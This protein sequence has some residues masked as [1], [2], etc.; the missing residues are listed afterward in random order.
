MSTAKPT[1]EGTQN[2]P[3]LP[4][5]RA[6]A[7]THP[8]FLASL[9][10][11]LADANRPGLA[12]L[13]ARSRDDFTP[14]LLDA[15]AAV[16]DTLGLYAE[17]QANENYLRT[18]TLRGSLR[19]HARL[20]GYELAPAKAA[21]VHL[22]FEA[23]PVDPAQA[24]LD[25][26]PGLRV[27]S[28]PRDG[29]LPL[30]FETV[31]P[32]TARAD[33]NAMRPLMTW[34]QQLA[35]EAEEITLTADGPRVNIGDA[36]L[37]MQGD[38][39]VAT[40]PDTSGRFLR[41]VSGLSAGIGGR[42][43][44]ALRADPVPA[45]PYTQPVTHDAI[46]SPGI[47]LSTGS[48]VATLAGHSWSVATL[49]Q[50]PD[51]G[52]LGT[53]GLRKAIEAA[54]FAAPAT[55]SPCVMR[56]RAGFFGNIA[57]PG[58]LPNHTAADEPGSIISTAVLTGD[59]PGQGGGKK[60]VANPA[61]LV[62]LDREY[63]EI[64][65]G[66]RLLIRDIANEAW[67]RV[68]AAEPQSIAAYGI[69]A[70]V[71]RLT[72]KLIASSDNLPQE[73]MRFL[74]KFLIRRATCHALPEPLPLAD[75]PITD[76]VGEAQKGGI[77]ADQVELATPELELVPGKTVA[78]TGTRADLDGVTATDIRTIAANIIL[79]DH[80]RLT[81][82]QPLTHRF[83][84]DSVRICANV[85][86][87]THGETVAE[88]MGDGDAT[89]TFQRFRLKSGPLTHV[90]ARN[91]RGMAP[92]LEIRVNRVRWDLVE[93][94]RASGPGDRVFI[95]RLDEDGAA[96]VIFGDGIRGARLPTGQDNVEAIYRR[97]AGLAGHLEAGQLSLLAG[98]PQGLR[99]VTNPLPPAG[100]ADAEALEDAR[101]NAPM[102]VMTLGR[103][104]SL[105]DYEDFARSFAAVA[106]ARADW[107]F[108][109]F[110][111]PILITVAGQGGAMLPETG[112]DMRNLRAALAAAGEADLRVSVRNHAPVGFGV[113]ARLFAD[114]AW[115]PE[116]VIAAAR[117]AVMAA[118]SFDR[119]ALG[120]AVSQAQVVAAL[121]AVPGVRGVDLDALY[122]G[123]TPALQTRLG[124]AVGRPD[125]HGALPVAAELLTLDPARLHLEVAT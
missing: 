26:P 72:V 27:R 68:V 56:L 101:R 113:A 24:V 31:E 16:L 41:R 43:I 21:S 47:P 20:I 99:G 89:R 96:H 117:Q 104:V 80:S 30:I 19:A 59:A 102:G 84:R 114:P 32:L 4:R 95:L 42:R 15:W 37:L 76:A 60:A 57:N 17:I 53:T 87:A 36:V 97:G 12:E 65:P 69:A 38:Q 25:Y 13:R 54:P 125:L 10:R 28:I 90:S 83:V 48:L 49:A 9:M 105:Q 88:V 14:G 74:D 33:W 100:G 58:L 110:A 1:P 7:G 120:Q 91:P 121:Q 123:T 2:R 51:F 67:M 119:R 40:S 63:P 109:G 6:R 75:L 107:T 70:K 46:W 73:A 85:A 82:T 39:P 98:K 34:P 18:A 122:R 3:G 55:I 115:M 64:T 45:R 66:Q 118:F 124:A 35:A 77:R 52:S 61:L 44:V 22:A 29:E 78:I 103:V 62:Y 50:A 108:D 5:L 79:Q 111:R 106:K 92:A 23:E 71:T 116:D 112:D 8:T 11:G 81:F 93:D 94:F 86:L